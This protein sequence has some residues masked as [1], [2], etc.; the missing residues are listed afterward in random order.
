MVPVIEGSWTRPLLA[1]TDS[2]QIRLDDNSIV[3]IELQCKKT[4]RL[5][6]ARLMES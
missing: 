3:R 1:S 5:I 2:V 6:E 4:S